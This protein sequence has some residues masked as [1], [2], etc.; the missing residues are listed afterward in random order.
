MRQS[1]SRRNTIL[2][3]FAVLALSV[4]GVILAQSIP[5]AVFPEFVFHRAIIL[6][7]NRRASG[8]SDADC[9]DA[10]AGG[11]GL[12]RGRHHAGALDHHA[13]QCRGRRQLRR[14]Q[15]SHHQ[16]RTARRR[17]GGGPRPSASRHHGRHAPAEHR[18]LPDSRSQPELARAQPDRAHRHRVLRSGPEPSSRRGR[19]PGRDGRRQVPRIRGAAG[20]GADAR[21]WTHARPGGDG[22]QAGQRGRLGRPPARPASHAPHGRHRRPAP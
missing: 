16:L 20:S 22:T 3:L 19:L 8:R 11:G 9:G 12:Q 4:L 7:D 13:R 1:M 2:S 10:T 5:N 6:A 21:A 15:R 18:D 17:A 14:E